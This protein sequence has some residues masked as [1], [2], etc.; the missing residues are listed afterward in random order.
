[1]FGRAIYLFVI[2]ILAMIPI[3]IFVSLIEESTEQ[4]NKRRSQRGYNRDPFEDDY[5]GNFRYYD[6][7]DMG[8]D[9]DD[10]GG[11]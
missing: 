10:G 6:C 8:A 11:E 9:G 5:Y 7:V 2:Y 3:G 4:A 1:M